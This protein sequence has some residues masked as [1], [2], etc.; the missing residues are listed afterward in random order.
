M[1]PVWAVILSMAQGDPLRAQEIEEGLTE[2]WWFRWL[3]W[4]SEMNR[5]EERKKRG[6][7]KT[8]DHHQRAR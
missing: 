6:N 8:R 5:A 7:L 4:N 2:E 1:P 3:A